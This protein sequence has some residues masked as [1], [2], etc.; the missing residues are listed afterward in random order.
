MKKETRIQVNS[1][2]EVVEGEINKLKFH[3]TGL[4]DEKRKTE[5][6]LGSLQERLVELKSYL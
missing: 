3:L 2:I 1:E 6:K 4:K 5:S